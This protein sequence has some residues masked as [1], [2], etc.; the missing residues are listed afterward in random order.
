MDLAQVRDLLIGLVK[1]AEEAV[2]GTDGKAKK[3]WCIDQ[4]VKLV[5]MGDNFIPVL[6]QW[7]DLPAVDGFERY[8]IGL[9][10]EWAWTT[11]KLPA[12]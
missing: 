4:A 11:L 5:E 7:A 8:I 1:A 2:P 12:A 9:G 3:Q 6:G 10:I